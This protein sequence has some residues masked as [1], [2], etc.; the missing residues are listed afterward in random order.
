M[1]SFAFLVRKM[2][3]FNVDR[4][5]EISYQLWEDVRELFDHFRSFLSTHIHDPPECGPKEFVRDCAKSYS[6]KLEA[7]F[8][9][10]SLA[11]PEYG[12]VFEDTRVKLDPI[13]DDI[14]AMY[15]D[16]KDLITFRV[17]LEKV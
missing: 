12:D 13:I 1:F 9:C 14:S 15:D 3:E 5:F 6:I 8:N 17:I 7:L 16:F 10:L 2:S 4:H 11:R